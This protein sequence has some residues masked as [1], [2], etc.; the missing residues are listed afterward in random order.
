MR[1][2]GGYIYL[3]L[4]THVPSSHRNAAASMQAARRFTLMPRPVLCS[5]PERAAGACTSSVRVSRQALRCNCKLKLAGG[6]ELSPEGLPAQRMQSQWHCPAGQSCRSAGPAPGAA[7]AAACGGPRRPVQAA[8][9]INARRLGRQQGCFK[10][11]RQHQ[12]S[13]YRHSHQDG[14][15][16]N[17]ARG[18]D[19]G[20][21]PEYVPRI[22]LLR[23]ALRTACLKRT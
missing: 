12:L 8:S 3:S 17:I 19:R 20:G 14:S 15:P 22:T 7:T 6:Q 10:R 18:D 13:K 2:P 23:R 4:S 5:A 11:F 1:T 21:M 16:L 9:V